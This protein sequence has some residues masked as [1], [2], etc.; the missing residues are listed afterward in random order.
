MIKLV[1]TPRHPR[2]RGLHVVG[3]TQ[4][5]LVGVDAQQAIGFAYGSD[6]TRPRSALHERFRSLLLPDVELDE[7]HSIDWGSEPFALGGYPAFG[8]DQLVRHGPSLRADHG[9]LLF[10]G[11]DRSTW[12]GTMEGAVRDGLR[13]ADVLAAATTVAHRVSTFD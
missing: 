13:L 12:P 11:A 4:L 9:R 6:T 8:P 10:G 1:G 3:D 2:K 7:V 5:P